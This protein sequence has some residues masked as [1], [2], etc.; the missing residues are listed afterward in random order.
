MR[1]LRKKYSRTRQVAKKKTMK[2]LVAV[3]RR[4]HQPWEAYRKYGDEN[5][6][7]IIKR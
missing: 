1:T 7:N 2:G 5:Y 6:E 4:A 3:T